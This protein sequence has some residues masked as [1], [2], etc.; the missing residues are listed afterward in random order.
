MTLVAVIKHIES[1][2]P[3]IIKDTACSQGKVI[4]N[5]SEED[6]IEAFKLYLRVAFIC[7]AD[8]C[9]LSRLLARL[10]NN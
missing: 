1:V 9:R 7:G 3:G 8:T 2:E 10:Q 6:K 4:S 5:L